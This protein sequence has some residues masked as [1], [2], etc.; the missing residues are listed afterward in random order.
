[1]FSS[2]KVKDILQTRHYFFLFILNFSNICRQ[3]VTLQALCT[4]RQVNLLMPARNKQ[5]CKYY[6]NDFIEPSMNFPSHQTLKGEI[7]Q[8]IY[9]WLFQRR[10]FEKPLAI[11]S[12]QSVK[13]QP[14]KIS[15]KCFVAKLSMFQ[16]KCN[17]VASMILQIKCS[18]WNQN[19]QYCVIALQHIKKID[20]T[21]AYE[22]ITKR[23]NASNFT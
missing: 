11:F 22:K 8:D 5:I 18:E 6:L 7:S 16:H 15:L 23:V 10:H 19:S 3:L 17:N 2:L 4:V 12:A 14:S 21:T 1:M 20:I 9:R 13:H